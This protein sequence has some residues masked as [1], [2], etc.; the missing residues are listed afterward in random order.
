MSVTNVRIDSSP[1]R[2]DGGAC[3]TSAARRTSSGG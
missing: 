3:I 1:C 2:D